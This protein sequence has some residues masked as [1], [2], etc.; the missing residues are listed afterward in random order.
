MT[1]DVTF[2][3]RNSLLHI[4]VSKVAD[5]KENIEFLCKLHFQW[6]GELNVFYRR[7]F[8]QTFIELVLKF[9]KLPL[10]NVKF[11][12]LIFLA[13]NCI[14]KSHQ[15][16]TKLNFVIPDF[17][18]P[19]LPH[20]EEGLDFIVSNKKCIL[21]DEMGVGKT[22]TVLAAL[23]YLKTMKN[24]IVCPRSVLSNWH[25][26]FKKFLPSQVENV[27]LITKGPKCESQLLKIDFTKPVFI[28]VSYSLLCNILPILKKCKLMQ[29][30]ILIGD[31]SHFVKHQKPKRS[32]IFNQLSKLAKRTI[33]LSATIANKPATMWNLLRLCNEDIFEKY[34]TVFTPKT[35]NVPK[36]TPK[37][38]RFA[39]RYI[40][41][42]VIHIA[43]GALQYEYKIPKR[44]AELHALTQPF[45]LRRELND[46]VDLPPL[47]KQTKSIGS[48]PK[49]LIKKFKDSFKKMDD[50]KDT[51]G[52]LASNVIFMDLMQETSK[53]REEPALAYLL[54][55]IESYH[56]KIL[57]F[58]AYKH[59]GDFLEEGLNAKKIPNIKVHSDVLEKNRDS[60]YESFKNPKSNVQ[61][62]LIS[63]GCG[64]FGLNFICSSLCVYADYNFDVVALTQSEGR[65]RRIGQTKKVIL[66]FLQLTDSTDEIVL[67]A[68][69]SQQETADIILNLSKNAE[70]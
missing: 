48:L 2:E 47:I 62:G 10:F 61:I 3:I 46:V 59:F 56:D 68:I 36:P 51:K 29:Y 32:K 64:G 18:M 42:K 20:Q 11:Y 63:I 4:I 39:E 50:I 69:Q 13:Q 54:D 21:A 44:L 33:Q 12:N 30:D 40:V 41:I 15:K 16:T 58:F 6:D 9:F 52:K 25:A 66:Q 22:A 38:F 7:D 65:C 35:M 49:K 67:K 27:V 45:V 19:L 8:D 26:E 60:L 24:L 28:I 53:A 57:V 23:A 70:S 5:T 31:E 1:T 14:L 37:E 43:G 34:H 55:L 17:Q